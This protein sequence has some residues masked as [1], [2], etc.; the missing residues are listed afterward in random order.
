MAAWIFLWPPHRSHGPCMKCS[1]VSGSISSQRPVFFFSNSAVKVYDS[2]AYRNMEMIIER[3]SFTFDLRNMLLSLQMGF[4]LVRVAVACAVLEIISGLEPSSKTTAP[5]YLKLVTVPNFC[6]LPLSLSRCHRRY[7]TSVWFSRHWPPSYTC[8]GFTR[9]NW[10]RKLLY[11]AVIG[12]L[13][14]GKFSR[15]DELSMKIALSS[16]AWSA[17]TFFRVCSRSTPFAKSLLM[18]F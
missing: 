1:I 11:F 10:A 15:S 7:L 3:T 9:V 6:P 17:A 18:G 2:Q 16:W 4:S 13:L 14:V 5:R 12:Y 8:A